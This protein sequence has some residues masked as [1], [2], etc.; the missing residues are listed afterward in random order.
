MKTKVIAFI[1]GA[2]VTLIVLHGLII[3]KTNE[4]A[5][6]TDELAKQN[7]V[8]INQVVEFL[9]KALNQGQQKNAK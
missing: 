5:K 8:S 7:Q 1:T 4:L 6:K 2:I 9:N 3:Y